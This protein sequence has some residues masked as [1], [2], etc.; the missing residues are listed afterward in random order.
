MKPPVVTRPAGEQRAAGC[1]EG[2]ELVVVRAN[3][4]DAVRHRGRGGD[5]AARPS[6]ASRRARAPLGGVEGIEV[7]ISVADID[8]AVR[9]RG[10]GVDFVARRHRPG[11]RARRRWWR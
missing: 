8:D 2:I 10:R 6:P 3:I 4:D 1:V 5:F 7:E 9:H 11:R